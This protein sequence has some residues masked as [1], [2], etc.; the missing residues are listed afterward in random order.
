MGLIPEWDSFTNSHKQQY[1]SQ[2]TPE[3]AGIEPSL[4][5]LEW[6]WDSGISV[7]AGDAISWEVYPTQGELSC[8]KYLLGGCRLVIIL[9]GFLSS[10]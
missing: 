2:S 4:E 5:L 8:H 6:I 10:L 7:V 3:H 9:P 1:A